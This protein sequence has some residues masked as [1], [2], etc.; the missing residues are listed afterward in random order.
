MQVKAKTNKINKTKLSV[1]TTAYPRSLAA[2][3]KHKEETTF[4]AFDTG[5]L[6]ALL[7]G[8]HVWDSWFVMTEDGQVADIN[9]H[10]VLIAL[11]RPVEGDTG[12]SGEKIAF[13]Y[14]A[15]GVHYTHGGFLFEQSI[16]DD[17]REWSGSTIK[18]DDGRIQTFYTISNGVVID[19]VWQTNQRF[20]TAIQTLEFTPAETVN[21]GISSYTT[22]AKLVATAP[23]VHV[24]LKE[25][26][27]VLYETAAQASAHENRFPCLHDR[28]RGSDQ[29]EN[30][31]FRDPKFFRDPKSGKKFL[32]FEGNTGKGDNKVGVIK[33]EYTGEEDFDP[34]SDD[35]KANGCVGVIEL[36]NDEY[37]FGVFHEPLLVAN[38]TTDEIERINVIYDSGYYY[39]FVCGHLNKFTTS[40]DDP[41]QI[42]VDVMLGF[43][44]KELLGHYKPLNDD[45][46][47]I[48]QKSFG[49]PYAGQDANR[50]YVYSWLMVPTG[51][52]GVFE[53]ISYANY[54]QVDG[55]IV[56]VKTSGPTVMVEIKGGYTRI[57]DLKYNIL[58]KGLVDAA[59]VTATENVSHETSDGSESAAASDDASGLFSTH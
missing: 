49:A 58:P 36:T 47:V 30:F 25:P 37:T 17:I 53:C 46:C 48:R 10:R 29:T 40:N 59:S 20:A 45:G 43:R 4:P 38:T 18:R 23:E 50:Q 33:E 14:S 44:S 2:Q 52:P 1:Q 19:G 7:D 26:D 9:G 5:R 8:W 55:E 6:G 42:N 28:S 54:C 21:D 51:T 35:I 34:T 16:Y 41:E 11:V 32:F 57:L 13:F 12:G 22:E 27:G 24:L 39:L 15:D 56:A 3:I 31:C